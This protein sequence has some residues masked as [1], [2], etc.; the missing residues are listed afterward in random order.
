M[1]VVDKNA[2][3]NGLRVKIR[4]AHTPGRPMRPETGY[5]S[6]FVQLSLLIA[7]A[8]HGLTPDADNL[9]ST[10]TFQVL[11][12]LP[13]DR[14]STTNHAMPSWGE[15]C[16]GLRNPSEQS[17]VRARCRVD[18]V[19]SP[20]NPVRARLDGSPFERSLATRRCGVPLGGLTRSLCRPLC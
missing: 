17:I 14:G 16:E 7:S 4:S 2:D 5:L 15:V 13:G 3:A 6:T 1:P 8:I 9:A 19:A 18:H 20:C 12:Q 10:K 11:C